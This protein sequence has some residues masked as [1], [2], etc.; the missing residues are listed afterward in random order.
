MK[1]VKVKIESVAKDVAQCSGFVLR[2]NSKFR[3]IFYPYLIDNHSN[4][5]ECIKAKLIV[6]RKNPTD[7]WDEEFN[8][9]KLTD[10]KRGEWFN[11]ELKASELELLIKY[12]T[13]LKNTYIFN[14]KETLFNSE[15]IMIIDDINNEEDVIKIL[16]LIKSNPNTYE[17]LS[18][19]VEISPEKVGK[20]L[21]NEENRSMTLDSISNENQIKIFNELKGKIINTDYLKNELTNGNEE[22][23]QKFFTEYPNVLYSVIPSLFQQ[24]ASKQYLGG[25][26][27]TNHNGVLG[28][29]LY[30]LGQNNVALIEIK[31]PIQ[32]IMSNTLYRNNV[33]AP[34]QDLSGAIVQIR[35][36]KDLFLKSYY[37][38]VCNSSEKFA[39]FDPKLYIIIGNTNSLNLEQK[40]C[41]ELF[42]NELKD[43]EI[44]CYDE[45]INKLDLIK[46]VLC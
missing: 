21:D 4:I 10:L 37:N 32:D 20:F 1:Y 9:Y 41:F 2:E 11:V 19:L 6:E 14:G 39:A 43:I 31:T 38:L 25:K 13:E 12:C 45:L 24:I 17:Y 22:F 3:Y 33:Y 23:W 40:E 15:K 42:R 28:D 7:P 16:D 5:N 29:F 30:K 35:K 26:D 36:Q 34:S 46:G 44:I 27:I 18:K 8:E